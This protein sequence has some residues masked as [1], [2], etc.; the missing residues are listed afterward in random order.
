VDL[1]T[2]YYNQ[3]KE[4][5]I[6][7]A[8]NSQRRNNVRIRWSENLNNRNCLVYSDLSSIWKENIEMVL[9][10]IGFEKDVVQWQVIL[11]KVMKDWIP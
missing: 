10:E 3:F 6:E 4:A 1:L 8:S 5:K 2:F 7:R 9:N 11:D